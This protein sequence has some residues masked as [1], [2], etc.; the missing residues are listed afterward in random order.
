MKLLIKLASKNARFKNFRQEYG[1]GIIIVIILRI[2]TAG[3]SIFAGYFYFANLLTAVNTE[4]YIIPIILAVGIL[5][6]VEILSAWLLSKLTKTVLNKLFI[7]GFVLL[8]FATFTFGLSF[9]SST[10]GLSMRQSK[11]ADVSVDIIKNANVKIANTEIYYKE[12]IKEQKEIIENIKKNPQ[13]WSGGKRQYLTDKQLNSIEIVNKRIKE[14]RNEKKASIVEVKA[15]QKVELKD[16]RSVMTSTA[17]KYYIFIAIILIVSALCSISLHIFYRIIY[18]EE[19]A[20][21][22]ALSE[23]NKVKQSL[24]QN[25]Q[26]SLQNEIVKL[27]SSLINSMT[28]QNK[29]PVYISDISNS[30][31]IGFDKKENDKNKLIVDEKL[32]AR[33]HVDGSK[34]G[35]GICPNCKNEFER[36]SHNHKY[37]SE[38]CRI[39]Y[40]EK[41]TGKNLSRYKKYVN[42]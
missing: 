16:N 31:K 6:I 11:Q 8:I 14:L 41:K 13:G 34:H 19:K 12:L 3:I 15:A 26:M 24:F 42:N 9:I 20:Q 17:D 28:I 5:I 2:L 37:C 4:S 35:R 7:R 22:S 30:K 40:A 29:E 32:N 10:N 36:K 1:L 23:F 27:S 39:E 18:R 38:L 21:E 33:T 25:L